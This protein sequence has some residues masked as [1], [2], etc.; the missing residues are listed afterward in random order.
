MVLLNQ[1]HKVVNSLPHCFILLSHTV[2]TILSWTTPTLRQQV[3]LFCPTRIHHF[4]ALFK[5]QSD[6]IHDL[7]LQSKQAELANKCVEADPGKV[8]PRDFVWK[9]NEFEFS[10]KLAVIVTISTKYRTHMMLSIYTQWIRTLKISAESSTIRATFS[11][12]STPP[13]KT[14][15]GSMEYGHTATSSA[16]RSTSF[17]YRFQL[18]VRQ[19][20]IRY[21]VLASVQPRRV[22]DECLSNWT[23]WISGL[24]WVCH[25]F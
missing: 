15:L 10:A 5:S 9:H 13:R 25:K 17:R 21:C 8:I 11:L 4:A 23:W 22:R 1:A 24:W 14:S 6:H 2:D 7:V 12:D 3:D 16:Q 19:A 18:E 20:R